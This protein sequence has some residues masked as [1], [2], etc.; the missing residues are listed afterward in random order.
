MPTN[1]I[2]PGTRR[3]GRPRAP[4]GV[5]ATDQQIAVYLAPGPVTV[6]RAVSPAIVTALDRLAD[7]EEQRT[8]R[9]V[10]RTDLLRQA[11]A[12]FIAREEARR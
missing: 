7:R 6:V 1:T 5:L 2:R 10:N 9:A 8:R 3:R 12:E 4:G 11:V